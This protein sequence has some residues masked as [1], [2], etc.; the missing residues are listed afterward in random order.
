MLDFNAVKLNNSN[1]G[2]AVE[3]A[4]ISTGDIA[5]IG[6]CIKFPKAKNYDEFWKSVSDGMDLITEFPEARKKDAS[7][8]LE[9]SGQDAEATRYF[10][11]AYLDEIDKF[12]CAFFQITPKEASLM[13]PNQRL[14]LE[15]AWNAVEDSGYGGK[16]LLGTRTGVYLGFEADAPHDYRSYVSKLEPS[17][18]SYAVPGNLTPIIASRI[19]YLL[20]LRGPSM[21]I[22]TACSSALVAIYTACR[23]IRNGVCEMA[24]AGSVKVNFLPVKGQLDFGVSSSD[25]RTRAFDDSSDGTGSGEGVAAIVLKSLSNAVK[26]GD[27]IYAVIKGASTN[28]DGRSIGITAP[29][30]LAQEDVIVNAWRDAGIDPETI[31]YIEAHGTGTK[32]GDPIEIDGIQ[33]AFGRYTDRK[34]FCAVGSVKTNMGHLD[35]AAGIAGFIKAVLALKHGEIPP[36]IHFSKPNKRIIFEQSPVYVSDRLVKWETEG[37]PRRCGVSSFGFSGT[38]CHIVLEEAGTENKAFSAGASEMDTA[39][40]RERINILAISAKSEDALQELV[41]DY[42][43]FF[44]VNRNVNL[45]N[46]CHTAN[47]G[48]GHYKYRLAVVLSK[49]GDPAGILQG[50]L[51]R[52]KRESI[53]GPFVKFGRHMIVPEGKETK[54]KG[55]YTEKEIKEISIGASRLVEAFCGS[56][57]SDFESISRICDLYVQGANVEWEALYKGNRFKRV[58]LPVYPF[59]RRRCWVELEPGACINDAA[60]KAKSGCGQLLDRCLAESMETEIYSTVFSPDTH[61][62]LGEHKIMGSSV[63]VGTAYLEMAVEACKKKLSG[64][65]LELEDILFVSPLVLKDGEEREVQLVIQNEGAF[66]RFSV[67]SRYLNAEGQ[68]GSQWLKHVEGKI[69]SLNENAGTLADLEGTLEDMLEDIKGRCRKEHIKPDVDAYNNSTVFDLGLRWK[70]I[71]DMY[72]GEGELLSYIRMSEEYF[73]ESENYFLHPSLLD[74]ALA[75]VPIIKSIF[76]TAYQDEKVVYLPFSYK[77][78]K[79]YKPIPSEFY[80]HIRLKEQ[81]GNKDELISFDLTLID[82]SGAIIAEI[83]EYMLKKGDNLKI[84]P[85]ETELKKNLFYGIKWIERNSEDRITKHE[86]GSVVIFKDKQGTGNELAGRLKSSGRKVIEVEAG[87]SFEKLNG[88]KYIIG[89]A[90]NDYDGFFEALRVENPAQIVHLLTLDKSALPD[91]S[92]K[93]GINSL[94][95]MVRA[96]HKNNIKQRMEIF[97]VSERVNRVT[98]EEDCT[99]PENATLF[100]LGKTVNWEFPSLKCRALDVDLIEA[101]D[102]IAL[103]MAL[104]EKTILRL[105]AMGKGM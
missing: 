88:C 103:E 18:V 102:V 94:F 61:W 12:D 11:G 62:V 54:E 34:Q 46:V 99:R 89:E 97:L 31:T 83:S 86:E 68:T 15:T 66:F 3:V 5:V 39:F 78:F 43:N 29:N 76:G 92:Q 84:R 75:T 21:S 50:W 40:G 27:N 60:L 8:Y 53:P 47:T 72:I 90:Q 56:E 52:E 41:K 33:R 93:K 98:G 73:S 55:E 74:N 22:D 45:E 10:K 69:F 36:S 32:L 87:E 48:R 23:E 37:T 4:E 81:K 67:V 63:L 64:E 91:E 58:S 100:G 57:F 16:K 28:Q 101:V 17:S 70:N 105:I 44:T 6:I 42:V 7:A 9:A 85:G 1:E 77:S 19:S 13:S 65:C 80:S 25:G 82:V 71:K 38:N 79:V 14:F 20:D 35:N 51:N 2:A 104:E 26:D 59:E 30:V 24:V 49:G 95:N 96:I